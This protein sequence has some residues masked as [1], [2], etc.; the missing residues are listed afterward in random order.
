MSATSAADDNKI[1][2]VDDHPFMQK[3]VSQLIISS[4]FKNV[5]TAAD[6]TTA[7]DKL[8]HQ[9]YQLLITDL[10]MT[11]VD[12]Y[13]IVREVRTGTTA[14]NRN[15]A[16]LVM[17]T[18]PRAD[19]VTRCLM[20]DINGFILK[21][22]D[23][24]VLTK[25][26]I[27]ALARTIRLKP[28]EAYKQVA[29]TW[30]NK[31]DEESPGDLDSRAL[32]SLENAHH[33]LTTSIPVNESGLVKAPLPVAMLGEDMVLADDLLLQ[34]SSVFMPKG[35]VLSSTDLANLKHKQ[36]QLL[37]KIIDVY[38]DVNRFKLIT[39]VS[40]DSGARNGYQ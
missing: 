27:S 9:K 34:D 40:G 15:L 19:L 5:E 11:P 7:L 10:A 2:L 39:E 30:S 25:K 1:L 33:F 29:H 21:P 14:N 32:Q 31:A 36:M 18:H 37:T 13:H 35:N 28:V 24:K 38:I 23:Q 26:I 16:V 4:G 12:G 20:F 22:V 6:G 8:H 3:V 17:T